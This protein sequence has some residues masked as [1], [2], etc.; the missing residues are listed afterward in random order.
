MDAPPCHFTE[1][2]VFVTGGGSIT[3]SIS[4]QFTYTVRDVE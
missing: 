1:N 2:P 4:V 3:A